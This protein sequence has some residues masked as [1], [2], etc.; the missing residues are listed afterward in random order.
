MLLKNGSLLS[1]PETFCCVN[2]INADTDSQINEGKRFIELLFG[3]DVIS[4]APWEQLHQIRQ[5]LPQEHEENHLT[6]FLQ[7]FI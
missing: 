2:T 7:L 1:F 6:A 4:S 5:S 3:V